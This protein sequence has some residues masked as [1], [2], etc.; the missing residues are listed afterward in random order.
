M[1]NADNPDVANVALFWLPLGAGGRF[2][3]WNGRRYEALAAHHEHRARAELYHS[4]LEV[5]VDGVRSTI[6]MTPVVGSK[7]PLHAVVQHG[8]VGYRALGHSRLFRYEVR[9]WRD[10]TIPD[11]ADAVGSPVSVSHDPA[12]A[13]RLLELV[14]QVPALTWG[15]DESHAGEMWNSNSITA[16]LLAR[17]HEDVDAIAPPVGGRAPGWRAGLV[18]AA[19]PTCQ[20]L[21]T[22]KGHQV[23]TGGAGTSA[24]CAGPRAAR[25]TP[26][27]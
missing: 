13:R 23:L 1:T 20:H 10:G 19:R 2:V 25:G 5:Y 7:A 27:R 14:P 15:R 18:V 26:P 12:S 22:D 6:E 3:R 8:P 9:R 24:W 21:V 17:A 4:A 16:W 11:L